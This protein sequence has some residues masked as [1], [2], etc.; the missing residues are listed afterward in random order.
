MPKPSFQR[1]TVILLQDQAPFIMMGVVAGI[2]ANVGSAF[3]IMSPNPEPG[4]CRID[5]EGEGFLLK[6]A[7][8]NMVTVRSTTKY[9][10][11]AAWN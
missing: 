1:T 10:G 11:D 3:A 6:I 8:A 4:I 2:A 9:I 7:D 5:V